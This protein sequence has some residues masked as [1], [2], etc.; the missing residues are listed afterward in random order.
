VLMAGLRHAERL[1]GIVGLSGYLPIAETTAAE[2]HAANHDT[3]VF[4]GHGTRDSAVTIERGH[5]ARDVLVALGYAVEWH[6]Y[7]ME[8]SVCREEI[9]DVNAF[10]LRVFAPPA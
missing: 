4:L 8:H 2:R 3:P 7:P 5:R 10:L 1:A 6:D 9:A